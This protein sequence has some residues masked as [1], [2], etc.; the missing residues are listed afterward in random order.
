MKRPSCLQKLVT[1]KPPWPR[2]A[3]SFRGLSQLG[4]RF[5]AKEQ[6]TVTSPGWPRQLTPEGAQPWRWQPGLLEGR[7][8]TWAQLDALPTPGCYPSPW[9]PGH[10]NGPSQS[11]VWTEEVA[12]RMGYFIGWRGRLW[13][14][15]P[16][17]VIY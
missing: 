10:H 14:E 3:S 15:N 6:R 11:H 8:H 13:A 9:K 5:P 12:Y 1:G 7:E 16:S 4:Q 17:L 2:Q